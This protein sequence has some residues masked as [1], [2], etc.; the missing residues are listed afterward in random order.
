MNPALIYAK[1]GPAGLALV[2]VAFGA[3]YLALKNLFYLTMVWR[4]FKQNF[5]TL[6]MNHAENFCDL[7]QNSDNPLIAIIRDIVRIHGSHSEDI[8]AEVGYLFHRNFEHVA[9]GLCYLKLIAAIAPLMGLLG[10]VLG[11][12]T[13]FQT[14]AENAAPSA[15]LLAAGIWEALITTVMGLCVAIPCLMVYYYLM[16]K[17]RGFHVE[18]IE[19]SYRALELCSG[20]ALENARQDAGDPVKA[21]H[22]QQVATAKSVRLESMH[23]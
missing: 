21:Q 5:L 6:E 3:L 15:G 8:R 11:M 20:K 22:P 12:L 7:C 18:A 16:L 23:A 9:K 2:F 4:D 14:I 13:V 17:F 1:I 10:T 19:H